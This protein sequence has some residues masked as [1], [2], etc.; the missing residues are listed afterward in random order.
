MSNN[1]PI[2]SWR[3]IREPAVIAATS[4]S[5]ASIRRLVKLG[6]FPKPLKLGTGQGGAIAWREDEILSW[7][8]ARQEGRKWS[9]MMAG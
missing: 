3:L 8:K 4:Y 7:V 6:E 2:P 9:A 1:H 5:R